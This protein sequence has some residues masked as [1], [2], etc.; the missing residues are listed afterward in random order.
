MASA[1]PDLDCKPML[2]GSPVL[3]LLRQFKGDRA[4]VLS[5]LKATVGAKAE[6]RSLGKVTWESF[7]EAHY[8]LQNQLVMLDAIHCVAVDYLENNTLLN[9]SEVSSLVICC[10][11]LF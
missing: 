2:L 6:R 9:F 5:L 11:C 8:P 1:I 4:T 7:G 10:C 3:A